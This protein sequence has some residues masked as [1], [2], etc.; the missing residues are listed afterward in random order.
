M[1]KILIDTNGE[2]ISL[3]YDEKLP[4]AYIPHCKFSLQFCSAI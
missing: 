3:E 2:S 1:K 4:T